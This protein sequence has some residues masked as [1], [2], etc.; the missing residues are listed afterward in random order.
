MAFESIKMGGGV[1]A[2]LN[3]A[4][5]VAVDAF[6]NK[7]IGFT[8]IFSLVE[9]TVDKYSYATNIYDIDEILRVSDEAIA[10]ARSQIAK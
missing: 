5:E 1:P 8:D 10:F 4:N 3:F 9:K 7:R 6:L 2:V